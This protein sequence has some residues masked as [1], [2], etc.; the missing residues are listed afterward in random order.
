[1]EPMV[2]EEA[3]RDLEDL[4]FDLTAKANSLTG[5]VH[6]IECCR[7]LVPGSLSPIAELGFVSVESFAQMPRR[8]SM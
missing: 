7:A 8:T 6:P 4:A 1:M 5:Q 2:P 3:N